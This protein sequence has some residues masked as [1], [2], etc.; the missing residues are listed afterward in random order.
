MF[1]EILPAVRGGRTDE[2]LADLLREVVQRVQESKKA[3]KLAL[4]LTVTPNGDDSVMVAASIKT[5]LPQVN[6]AQTLFF[7]GPDGTL[8]RR[9]PRQLAMEDLVDLDEEKGEWYR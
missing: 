8:T 1:S 6:A 5:T 7:V 9:N 4:V 2:E 3:G